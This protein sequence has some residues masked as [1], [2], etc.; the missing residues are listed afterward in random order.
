MGKFV[1]DTVMTETM[2]EARAI[3]RYGRFWIGLVG[4]GCVIGLTGPFGTYDTMPPAL[5]IA[6]WGVVVTTTY[7]LGYLVSFA[8]AS[9]A[10]ARGIGTVASIGI[11]AIIASVPVT[12][13]L[14]VLHMMLLG[15]PF[16][17]EA[18]QLLPYVAVITLA[19][20]LIT[21]V[22]V[23]R[24]AVLAEPVHPPTDPDWLD[25]L[26]DHLG[27]NLILLHAQDHYVRAETALGHTLIRTR[28][29]DAARDLG[30]YG[31]RLHRSWW[32]ARHAIQS[33]QYRNGATVVTLQN[34]KELP[35]GRTYR[36][37]VK[38]ALDG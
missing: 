4:V 24:Q 26:P 36:R 21:E 11:G 30:D 13:W 22:R 32:A 19:V 16:V 38:E 10:E 31:V 5:R 18:L 33:Y 29:H 37:S 25:Q 27:R 6:Y 23:A 28:L 15:A 8:V 1:N 17:A 35:V 3:A 12:G 20:A 14:A 2:A 9:F 34:G 7:W